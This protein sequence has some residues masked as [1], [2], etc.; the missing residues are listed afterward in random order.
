MSKTRRIY[1]GGVEPIVGPQPPIN[2]GEQIIQQPQIPPS[3]QP[4]MPPPSEQ[5][6]MPPSEQI[7]QQPIEEQTIPMDQQPI[8]EQEQ[9]PMDQ[10][11]PIEEQEQPIDQQIPMEE[12]PMEEQEQPMEEQEQP[13]EEQ[14]QPEVQPV[15]ELLPTSTEE[16]S[17]EII[18]FRKKMEDPENKRDYF[19]INRN[20]STEFNKDKTYKREGIIHFSD[21]IGINAVRSTITE[22]T[23]IFGKKGIETGIYDKLRNT[24]LQKVSILLGEN[25]RSYNT[26]IEIDRNLDTIFIHIYGTVYV[27]KSL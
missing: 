11:I 9:I 3:E 26:R 27:K 18:E 12:Q 7:D 13:M 5:P 10:Q 24:A 6:Q 19:Y 22:I 21:S 1:N 14:E 8:E 4:Q 16:E 23:N 20:I 17:A 15:E 25:R 2:I